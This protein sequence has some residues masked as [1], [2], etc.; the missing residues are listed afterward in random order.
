MRYLF[1]AVALAEDLAAAPPAALERG[2]AGVGVGVGQVLL[3]VLPHA[4]R[5]GAAVPL[6]THTHTTNAKLA[7]SHR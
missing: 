7:L 4:E 6:Q 1:G 2:E 3:Q 5:Q